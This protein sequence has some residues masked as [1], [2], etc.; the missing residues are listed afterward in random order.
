MYPPWGAK[1]LQVRSGRGEDDSR[2]GPASAKVLCE[3][4]IVVTHDDVSTFLSSLAEHKTTSDC[5]QKGKK[6]F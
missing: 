1:C 4:G 5:P 3:A 6:R 2:R